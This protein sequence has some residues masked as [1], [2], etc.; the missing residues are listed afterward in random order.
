MII[1]P[2]TPEPEEPTGSMTLNQ[3]IAWVGKHSEAG[4]HCPCCGRMAKIYKRPINSTQARCLIA[5]Y[6]LVG[7]DW[8]HLPTLRKL[9]GQSNREESK[10]RYWGLL[11]EEKARRPDGGRAGW[12]RITDLGED[13]V[14]KRVKVHKYTRVYANVCLEELGPMV[15][16]TD[17]LGTHF[18]YN[19]L[20]RGE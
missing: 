8:A 18:N 19:E 15:D 17:S 6:K 7:K 3:A 16:I 1:V 13:F 20:M 9:H 11:E 14:L 10:L 12:W 4:C 2:S 5:Q